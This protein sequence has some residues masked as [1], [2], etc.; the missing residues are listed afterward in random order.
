MGGIDLSPMA[1]ILAIYF[2]RLFVIQS[3]IELGFRLKTGAML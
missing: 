1:V 2:V 3:I